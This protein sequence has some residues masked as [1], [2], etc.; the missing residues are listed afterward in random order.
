M[1]DVITNTSPL[2]YLYRLG[3]I[4][5][6]PQMF[7]SVFTTSAV[8]N[9]LEEGLRLGYDVPKTADYE[10]LQIVEPITTPSE[11][12]VLELGAG[13]LA[14]MSLALE[15]PTRIVL[16][17]DLLARRVAQD[18]GLI[19]WGTLKVLLEAK[20]NGL[21][22]KISPMLDKLQTSG[23]WMSEEIKQRILT[24]ADEAEE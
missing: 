13:E 4:D 18:S 20:S 1:P 11:W 9:E 7:D 10:W 23:M 19:V 16:L 3:G 8:I 15:N 5:W 2:L 22:D 17:D 12:L 14:V 6:L 21:T 24:L